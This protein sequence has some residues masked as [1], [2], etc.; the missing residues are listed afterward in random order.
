[1][2]ERAGRR[3]WGWPR[4]HPLKPGFHLAEQEPGAQ[5]TKEGFEAA[6]ARPGRSPLPFLLCLPQSGPPV[7]PEKFLVTH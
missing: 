2:R 6:P 3:G 7:G 1:M 4:S 5:R